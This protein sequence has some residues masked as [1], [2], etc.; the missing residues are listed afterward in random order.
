MIGTHGALRGMRDG[1]VHIR[2]R[3]A[4][5]PHPAPG[6]LLGCVAGEACGRVREWAGGRAAHSGSRSRTRTSV[7]VTVSPSNA[8]RPVSI[9]NNTQPN[10]QMSVT[11]VDCLTARLLG[12]HVGRRSENAAIGRSVERA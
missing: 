8:R 7:S 11:F 6:I 9:S 12:A 10:T 2:P 4:D 1:V 5:V 3:V